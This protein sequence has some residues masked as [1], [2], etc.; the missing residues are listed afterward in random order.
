MRKRIVVI[1]VGNILLKDDGIGVHVVR[2]I[3]DK[4]INEEW[5]LVYECGALGLQMLDYLDG[6]D[7]AV[8]VDAVKSGKR[9][10]VVSRFIIDQSELEYPKDLQS[11]HQIDV[12]ATLSLGREMMRL[13]SR[14][15]V[16]GIEPKDVSLGLDLSAEVKAS[17]GEAVQLILDEIGLNNEC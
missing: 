11:M 7:Y 12:L 1:G 2:E 13:P 6:A 15:I 3:A 5:V 9:P 4:I 8:I 17:M 16:V 14:I 10:G